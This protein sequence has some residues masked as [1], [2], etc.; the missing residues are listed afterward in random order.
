MRFKIIFNINAESGLGQV[1]DV[2]FAGN[3]L[4]GR[5]QVALDGNCFR[6]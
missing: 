4:I 1:A 6:R 3:N 2:A 5:A